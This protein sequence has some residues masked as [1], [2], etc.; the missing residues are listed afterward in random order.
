MKLLNKDL[1]I[2]IKEELNKVLNEGNFSDYLAGKI[3]YLIVGHFLSIKQSMLLMVR[4]KAILQN[5]K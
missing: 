4:R 5:I 3:A 1:K 2:I